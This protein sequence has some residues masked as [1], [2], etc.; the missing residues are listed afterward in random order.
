MTAVHL[1]GNYS[2]EDILSLEGLTGGKFSF[3]S[4]KL[5]G[6]VRCHVLV[7]G[8]VTEDQLAMCQGLR[9]VVVPY[10]GIPE[11]TRR[12]LEGHPE[13]RL[14]SIHHNAVSASEMAVALMLAAAKLLIPSDTA[15]R[16]NDWSPRYRPEGLLVEDSRVT[17][18]GFGA[19]GSRVGRICRAMG[20][21]V[22]GIS[23][24][25]R[26]G[27]YTPDDL[28]SLLPETDILV[29]CVPL[30]SETEGMIGF[31]ELSLLPRGSVLV[32]V[33][34]GPVVDEQALYESL[35]SG[36]LAG[37]GID[38]WY[39]YPDREGKKTDTPPSRFDFASLPNVVMS[40]HRGGAFGLPEIE[41]R[42][43]EHLAE[44]LIRLAGGEQ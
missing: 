30:T 25:R 17:V 12:A 6:P 9:L 32:N 28:H 40:P 26:E 2:A 37:A 23:K 22:R 21:S 42:R 15:L 24:T 36:H 11:T 27:L 7:A 44:A 34:R 33:A 29:V 35:R 16:R 8:R 10:A 38:V 41:R 13:I 5:A 39:S 3:T 18:L 19:I 43:L 1:N 14:E 20:A 31:R 4:G